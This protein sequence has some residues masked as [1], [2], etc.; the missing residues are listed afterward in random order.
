M[1][2]RGIFEFSGTTYNP[3]ETMRVDVESLEGQWPFGAIGRQ[4]CVSRLVCPLAL[5]R[6]RRLEDAT[7]Q[8][9]QDGL[10]ID[11]TAAPEGSPHCTT[12]GVNSQ[13]AEPLS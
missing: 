1:D 12:A 2:E 3:V 7:D 4:R 10:A 5:K 6:H 13:T 8:V 11:F 9:D